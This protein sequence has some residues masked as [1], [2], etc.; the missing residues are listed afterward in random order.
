MDDIQK[1]ITWKSWLT[2]PPTIYHKPFFV[3]GRD[4][5]THEYTIALNDN[6]I[7]CLSGDPEFILNMEGG[8]SYTGRLI[9]TH[10]RLY[11]DLTLKF[12]PEEYFIELEYWIY[13][14]EL[15]PNFLEC[16]NK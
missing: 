4:V 3:Y 7:V 5:F 15:L 12:H 1:Q 8:Y 11:K 6:L 2:N 9:N 10:L 14:D 13:L 16:K